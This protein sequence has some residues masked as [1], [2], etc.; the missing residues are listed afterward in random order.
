MTAENPDRVA[1]TSP[2]RCP[3]CGEKHEVKVNRSD[4]V[5]DLLRVDDVD[6]ARKYPLWEGYRFYYKKCASGDQREIRV[7]A[8]ESAANA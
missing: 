4:E 3:Y 6:W 8:R 5:V 1:K 7:I 2:E